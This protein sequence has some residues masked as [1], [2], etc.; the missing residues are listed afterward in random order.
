M[1]PIITCLDCKESKEHRGHGLCDAC[2]LRARR[3]KRGARLRCSRPGCTCFSALSSLDLCKGHI[4]AELALLGSGEFE[5]RIAEMFAGQF[6]VIGEC[7]E[8]SGH[9]HGGY[10]RIVL[11]KN[12][13]KPQRIFVHHLVVQLRAGRPLAG[14]ACH[15][16][17]NRPCFRPS[18]LYEGTYAD[19][20][21]DA[22]QRGRTA[23]GDRSPKTKLTVAQIREI[24]ARHRP[25]LSRWDPGNTLELAREFGVDKTTIGLLTRNGHW[26]L[27]EGSATGPRRG[28]GKRLTPA[29]IQEIATRHRPGFTRWDRGNTAQLAKEFG[30]GMGTIRKFAQRGHSSLREAS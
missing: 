12:H 14:L 6:A 26:S 27:P 21:A 23:R 19:N 13:G 5:E 3:L 7:W 15:H 11:F 4:G 16:C 30:V 28:A 1:S 22:V 17:D 10:G 29:E 25:G 2:Y 18:H 8:F 24:V 9:R 20:A